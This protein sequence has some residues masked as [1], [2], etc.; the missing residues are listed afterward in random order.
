MIS[1]ALATQV[2]GSTSYYQIGIVSAGNENCAVVNI[3]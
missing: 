3:F 1:A 2:W